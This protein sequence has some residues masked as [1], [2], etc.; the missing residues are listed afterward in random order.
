MY[1]N[2]LD[3]LCILPKCQSKLCR[4]YLFTWTLK[5][6]SCTSWHTWKILVY[7]GRGIGEVTGYLKGFDSIAVSI[8]EKVTIWGLDRIFLW[9]PK[10]PLKTDNILLRLC[11]KGPPS[12]FLGISKNSKNKKHFS[13]ISIII[14]FNL[15]FGTYK[16]RH[17][18]LVCETFYSEFET[19]EF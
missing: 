1:G 8:C 4:N 18:Y 16:Y 14:F 3:L 9:K 7:S 12:C 6:S 5:M 11:L 10:M 2:S 15:K 17:F 13:K 19:N